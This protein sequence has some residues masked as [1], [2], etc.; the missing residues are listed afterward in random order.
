[1]IPY[2]LNATP[3]SGRG[4]NRAMNLLVSFLVIFLFYFYFWSSWLTM[5]AG[6]TVINSCEFNL[7]QNL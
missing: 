1:M 7:M 6:V 2:L 4:C 5:K 3:K